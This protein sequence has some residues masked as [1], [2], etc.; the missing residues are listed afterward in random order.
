MCCEPITNEV[1]QMDLLQYLPLLTSVLIVPGIGWLKTKIKRDVPALYL[2]ISVLTSVGASM[3]AGEALGI[4]PEAIDL[5]QTLAP[6][7]TLLLHSFQK[8]GVK[9]NEKNQIDPR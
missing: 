4:S 8:G 9:S 5:N 3:G 1:C 6:L 2:L 7:L